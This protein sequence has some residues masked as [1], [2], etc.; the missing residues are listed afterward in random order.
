MEPARWQQVK[1]IFQEARDRPASDRDGFIATACGDDP[2]LRARVDQLLA[3]DA[4]AS[5][6][7]AA[8]TQG[9]FERRKPGGHH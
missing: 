4:D 3:A 8:P 5:G 6:F 1:Q 2:E 9:G 7:L